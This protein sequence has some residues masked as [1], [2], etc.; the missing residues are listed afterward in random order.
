MTFDGELQKYNASFLGHSE[1]SMA[2]ATLAYTI[3]ANAGRRPKEIF[4][5]DTIRDRDGTKIFE[6][7]N[8][9]A[10]VNVL[11]PYA[12]YQVHSALT[13]VMTEGTGV[14]ARAEYGLGDFP[15][16]GKTGTSYGSED[17]W[18]IGY[19]D[20]VTLAVWA[21]FDKSREEIYPN[22]YSN[23]TVLP[24]WVEM[25]N[26]ANESFPAEPIPAPVTAH[27]IEVCKI[28][29][30]RA[31]EFCYHTDE[32]DGTQ[33][34]VH[35]TYIEFLNPKYSINRRCAVHSVGG[36]VNLAYNQPIS[37][38]RSGENQRLAR[39]ADL[40]AQCPGG[41]HAIAHRVGR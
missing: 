38:G 19:T 26:L 31:T 10:S 22:A 25:M 17:N 2:E 1:V 8:V 33:S 14:K 21:G 11:D 4:V 32:V 39:E 3:F 37:S 18:F 24:T 7:E 27:P 36:K 5:I 41:F 13:D 30:N 40:L 28:S 35:E 15:V 6:S 20:K 34:R 9:D 23:D 12:A 16:A 29:G